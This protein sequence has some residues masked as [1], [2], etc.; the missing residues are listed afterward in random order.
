MLSGPFR[1]S[2]QRMAAWQQQHRPSP[3]DVPIAFV[4]AACA[5][6]ATLELRFALQDHL[7]S[8]PTLVMFILPIMASAY[9]GGLRAGLFA[10]AL[11]CGLAVYFLV[12]PFHSF[13]IALPAQRWNLFF[14]ILAGV[15]ISA[16]CE[17]L[18]RVRRQ[19]EA[20]D[21]RLRASAELAET[22]ALRT[23]I[24]SSVNFSSIAIDTKG[25]IQ[26][27]SIG[28]ERMLGYSAADMVNSA[29][30][31]DFHDATESAERAAA[32]S[33]EFGTPVA[34]GFDALVFKAARGIVDT[35]E[36]TKIRKDGSR[37]SA[38][39]SVTALRDKHNAIIGYLLLG[40]DNTARHQA[41]AERRQLEQQLRDQHFYTRSLIESNID[42]LMTIDPRGVITDVNQQ[43]EALCGRTR[44]ELIGAP[45]KSLFTDATRAAS[46]IRRVLT[47]GKVSNFELTTRS[48]DGTFTVVSCNATTFHDRDQTLKGVF[49]A[50]RDITERN[51]YEASLQRAT[52]KA[53]QASRAK[54]EFLANMS[55]EIRTPMNAVIGLSYLLGRTTLDREQAELLAK[56][57]LA[58]KAL[59]GLINNVLDLSKIEAGELLVEHVPFSPGELLREL[60]DVMTVQADA[61][62]VAFELDVP[63]DL[64]AALEGDATRLRQI[65]TNLLSNAVKFTERGTVT[66]QVRHHVATD[67]KATVHFE[68]RETGIGIAVE[69]Q[70]RLF[71]SFAQADASIT[72]R[73]GGTGLGLSIVKRLVALAGGTVEVRSTAGKGSTFKVDLDFSIAPP[74]SLAV[75][76]AAPACAGPEGLL[77]VRVLVVDDSD[78][79][80]EVTRRILELQGADVR[81]AGNGLAA[82]Q[83]LRAEPRMVDVVLM[84]VQMP[85]LDGYETTRRIRMELGLTRLP[86]IAL[87]AGAVSSERVRGAAAGMDDYIVKP[88]D[89]EDL[90]SN[91]LRQLRLARDRPSPID[92]GQTKALDPSDA[93]AHWPVIDGIDA[94]DASDRL[95]GDVGLFCSLLRRLVE[96]FSDMEVPREPF[97]G[98]AELADRMHRLSGSAGMLGAHAIRDLARRAEAACRSRELDAVVTHM[99]GLVARLD[100][101]R[102]VVTRLEEKPW[103]P[104]DAAPNALSVPDGDAL[105]ALVDLLRQQSLAAIGRFI[106][107]SDQLRGMLSESAY[108]VVR[109]HMNNLRYI[110]AADALDAIRR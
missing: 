8:Q 103:P 35:Y 79:N 62:G 71:A 64:P 30:P 97:G 18:R 110:D 47:E 2:R 73:F 109:D 27:F 84:D 39:L 105:D 63:D 61:K 24:F 6:F 23:A 98:L 51:H 22:E 38:L 69:D 16:L 32:L 75:I 68:V 83:M 42:A 48:R 92:D 26:I 57:N 65:L 55:H 3:L 5:T 70:A 95:G 87:T 104:I 107:I 89:A 9:V 96:D 80:L 25:V 60:A 17:N 91:I 31:E 34:P 21:L 101:L 78:I 41:E 74:S 52:V 10:T 44:D 53:E 72:R 90:V 82:F 67:D 54:G 15:T 108:D 106:S 99:A 43:T 93:V 29:R 100:E 88:F 4:F 37:F 45:F 50:A 46:G 40:T 19:V 77:G 12:P 11:S 56:I 28:S 20:A 58:S 85:V 102:Q 36:L 59:L 81:L 66:L 76:D 33:I 7:G 13:R 86:I 1:A 94:W 14:E 49:M